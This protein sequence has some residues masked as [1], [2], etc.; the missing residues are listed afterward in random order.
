MA[1]R[2]IHLCI[3][4]IISD[5]IEDIRNDRF[6]FGS[7]LPDSAVD[8]ANSGSHFAKKIGDDRKQF[9]F[10][11]FFERFRDEIFCDEMYQGYYF[12]LIQDGMFR[13]FVYY[14]L[15]LLKFRG[16]EGFLDRLYADYHSINGYI[17]KKYSLRDIPPLPPDFEQSKLSRLCNF[18]YNSF[19]AD[20]AN[21]FSDIYRTDNAYVTADDADSF[22]HTAA[23]KCIAEY[24]AMYC[25][26]HAVMP[27]EFAWDIK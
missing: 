25:G 23:E 27:S 11:D 2:M 8:K 1:S 15:S 7:I 21:D 14:D 17:S 3:G 16:K 13:K 26:E 24:K 20:M 22:I 19:S 4:K 9:D 5:R 6:L 18:D 12:H 10:N